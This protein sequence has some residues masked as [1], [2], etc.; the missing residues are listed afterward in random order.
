[1]LKSG[2]SIDEALGSLS[3]QARSKKL[4]RIIDKIKKRVEGGS[5]LTHS[6]ADEE[7]TFGKIFIG[8]VQAGEASGTLTENLF[9]LSDWFER[10]ND[11]KQEMRSAT[12]YPKFVLF[13]SFVLMGLLSVYILP[14]LVPLFGQL[15][16]TLPLPTRMLLAFS[17]FVEGYWLYSLLGII[18]ILIGLRL[19]NL[20]L[21]VKRIFHFLYL[22]IPFFGSLIK[23]YQLA[24]LSQLFY[25]LFKSGLTINETIGIASGSSTNVIYQEALNQ[26]RD[27]VNKGTALSRCMAD[28]P[29]ICPKNFINIVAIGEK[30][31][32]LDNSFLHL[33][34]F[35]SK[36]VRIK[37]KRLPTILEPM[38]LILMGAIVAFVAL[39]IIMPI[40][41]LT[42]SFEKQ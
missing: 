25:T 38:L 1:M 21:P 6:F 15:K 30:T 8:L 14:K 20:L 40:Y 26:I 22:R 41:E 5:S 2:I 34:E 13:S 17:R 29:K 28:Y 12:L 3:E 19:L 24:L 33:S 27:R 39:S 11:L 16:V 42:R 36:E 23:D 35:Y 4:S 18:L 37:T 9:F 7:A 31:G 10:N 32:T